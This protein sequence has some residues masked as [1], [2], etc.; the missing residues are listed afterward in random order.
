[1]P[2]TALQR[3]FG[4]VILAALCGVLWWWKHTSP[5]SLPQ[6]R[7]IVAAEKAAK[8]VS[9]APR[10][11]RNDARFWPQEPHPIAMRYRTLLPAREFP[12]EPGLSPDQPVMWLV[13]FGG[14]LD[15]QD[16][17]TLLEKN[18]TVLMPTQSNAFHAR[19]SH[20][21]LKAA[22]VD[23]APKILGWCRLHP[24]EKLLPAVRSEL[25][26]G[27]AVRTDGQVRRRLELYRGADVL[28]LADAAAAVGARV[29]SVDTPSAPGLPNLTRSIEVCGP[30]GAEFSALLGTLD[31]VYA[32]DYPRPVKRVCN[33]DAANASHITPMLSSPENLSG[34]GITVLVRDQAAIFNHPDYGTRLTLGPDV[35]SETPV[36]HST[37]V[38]GTI[39]GDGQA[40]LSALARGMAPNSTIISFDLVGDDVQEPLDAKNSFNATISN[41]SYGFVTGWEGG[42]FT[43]NQNTFGQYSTFARS[44][45]E[46]VR[47]ENLVMIKAVGNDRN[48]SGPGNPHDGTLA[49]DGEYYDTTDSSST[50]KNVLIVGAVQ[51]GIQA[52][53]PTPTTCVLASSSSGPSDDGRLRPEIVANGDQVNSCNNSTVSGNEYIR[54][55]GTSMASAVVAGATALFMERFKIRFGASASASPHYIRTVYA[56]TATDLGRVGPDYLHG[57][58]MLD[59]TAAISLFEADIASGARIINGTV[60]ATTGERFYILNSDGSTPIKATLCWTDDPGDILALRAIVN[61]LD[62]RLVRAS[63]QTESLPFVLDRL[64]PE[65]PATTGVN[66]VDTIEQLILNA[67]PAGTYLLVVRATNLAT[68][69]NFTLASSNDLAETQPPV[70][71]I[72]SSSL[73]GPSPFTVNFDGSTSFANVGSIT[74]YAWDF[75]DGTT[76]SGPQVQHTYA[77]GSFKAVLK[78][79]D[80]IGASNASAVTVAVNNKLPTAVLSASPNN[81]PAPLSTTLTSFGSFDPDG[82]ITS[83]EWDLGDGSTST[84]P[85][86]NHVYAA[87]GLYYVTLTVTDNGN[88]KASRSLNILAGTP[89]TLSS[90]TF[91]LNFKKLAVDR[92]KLTSKTVPVDPA[93]STAGLSGNVQVGASDFAFLLDSKGH[94]KSPQLTVALT[95][96]RKTLVVSVSRADLVQGLSKTGATSKDVKGAFVNIPFAFVLSDGTVWG[97]PGLP[98]TYNATQGRSGAGKLFVPK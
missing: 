78:V 71:K 73:I 80:S 91:N 79:V 5:E 17:A 35:V 65:K 88:A 31:W 58:G 29:L 89:I 25:P 51:D 39:G 83:F 43:N 56:Q 62:L 41:H 37:H 15:A 14:P 38:A 16:R 48:D 46:L 1:M 60:D 82:Q 97:S 23:F 84:L 59:L 55:T 36:Q 28:A 54:L 18:I 24:D 11:A 40:N 66:N 12:G 92:F 95:P 50:S 72:V 74:Q 93:L 21:A 67:P 4:L 26:P 57:F 75:G 32:V 96:K 2:G 7:I 10:A 9:P 33:Q 34:A 94:F 30:P 53:I 85:Q 90:S 76:G 42:V 6:P 68:P 45:D 27:Y 52:G 81:G 87:A 77:D 70:A 86:V 19:A 98:Y 3:A 63:D 13:Q 22:A 44:W 20:A 47:A 64:A 61:D 69:T 49:A 8:P